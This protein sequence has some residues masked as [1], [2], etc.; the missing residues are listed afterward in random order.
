MDLHQLHNLHHLSQS[1][2]IL[3]LSTEPAQQLQLL[4]VPA[5][6]TTGTGKITRELWRNVHGSTLSVVPVNTA[7]AATSALTSFEAPS[8]LGDNYGQRVR[9]YVTAPVSGQ[10]TFWIAA[11]D[12]AELYLSTSEDPA[13]KTR[14]A[15]ASTWTNARE[16]NKTAGQQSAKITLEAGKRYYIEALMLQGGGSDNLAVGWQLPD[17]AMERP[18]AGNRLSEMGTSAPVATAPTAPVG[19]I[20]REFWSGVHGSFL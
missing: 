5:S 16:W 20:T 7:P 9:G 14:I 13:R 17:G 11:D 10:Y 2:L 6:T 1:L 12:I 3:L 8:G 4:M 19:K 15:V 18:I